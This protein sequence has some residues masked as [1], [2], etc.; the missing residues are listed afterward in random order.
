MTLRD[1]QSLL[2]A[3]FGSPHAAVDKIFQKLT[4]SVARSLCDSY[5]PVSPF[6]S[7]SSVSSLTNLRHLK[8]VHRWWLHFSLSLLPIT[9]TN[10]V[11]LDAR[12]LNAANR[13]FVRE[14]TEDTEREVLPLIYE[15]KWVA[16][17]FSDGELGQVEVVGQADQSDAVQAHCCAD[18]QGGTAGQST[19]LISMISRLPTVEIPL[20][21]FTT[22]WLGRCTMYP[23]WL[24]Q[25]S[26]VIEWC[27]YNNVNLV[28]THLCWRFGAVVASFVVDS[29]I[30]Y[31]EPS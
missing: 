8:F 21:C 14:E 31:I 10:A 11:I 23:Y 16:L 2:N 5:P 17:F 28:D 29:T 15:I 18:A 12:I 24:P 13:K 30:R 27:H 9:V 26:K 19:Q 20:T 7:V 25:N 6:L 4:L 1:I 22:A 3:I